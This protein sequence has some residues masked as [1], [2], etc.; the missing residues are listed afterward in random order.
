MYWRKKIGEVRI[1]RRIHGSG[2]L[3][4]ANYN[5]F[6]QKNGIISSHQKAYLLLLLITFFLIFCFGQLKLHWSLWAEFPIQVGSYVWHGMYK[7]LL[8]RYQVFGTTLMFCPY[9]D[10]IEKVFPNVR[11]D[12]SGCHCKSK[13]KLRYAHFSFFCH[14]L[15]VTL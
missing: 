3:L 2:F 1:I 14:F 15:L 6:R 8:F 11:M 10:Q 5:F 7:G 13:K 9:P 12:F 4:V